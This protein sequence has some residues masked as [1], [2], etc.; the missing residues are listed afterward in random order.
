MTDRPDQ[1]TPPPGRLRLVVLFGG[2]SAEH[3]VSC[4]SAGS[5]LGAA[6]RSRYE[7]VPIG[8]TRDGEWVRASDGPPPLATWIGASA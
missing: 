7:V 5:V 1:P 6:D 8:I 3:E 4:I 2:Q